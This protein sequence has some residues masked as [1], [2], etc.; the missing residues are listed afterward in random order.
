MN[1]T[2]NDIVSLLAL[3]GGFVTTYYTIREQI[4]KSVQKIEHLQS[5]VIELK[6]HNKELNDSFSEL[7]EKVIELQAS[8][9]HISE[10]VSTIEQHVDSLRTKPN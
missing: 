10:R 9:E 8:E 4:T 3:L 6:E 7:T 1:I 5:L 2:I